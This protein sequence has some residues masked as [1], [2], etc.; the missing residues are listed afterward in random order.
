MTQIWPLVSLLPWGRSGRPETHRWTRQAYHHGR[1]V[2]GNFKI[3]IAFPEIFSL[4]GGSGNVPRVQCHRQWRCN[5]QEQKRERRRYIR[6]LRKDRAMVLKR[7]GQI[8]ETTQEARQAERGTDRPQSS[9]CK[10]LTGY[11]G[12]RDSLV[13][14]FPHVSSFRLAE[15]CLAFA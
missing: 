7:G 10:H 15:L 1:F 6:Q 3:Q 14:I 5:E 4:L 9:D 12:A 2:A 13:H 11:R 8:I